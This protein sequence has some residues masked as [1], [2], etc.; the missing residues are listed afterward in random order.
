M[1][2]EERF[3]KTGVII[4]AAIII[5]MLVG[6]VFSNH[7]PGI[8]RFYIMVFLAFIGVPIFYRLWREEK[9][10][11]RGEI[12]IYAEDVTM[13]RYEEIHESVKKPEW[14]HSDV[15]AHMKRLKDEQ[16]R[17]AAEG[18]KSKTDEK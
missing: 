4:S 12:D 8:Q 5:L 1:I 15:S 17:L 11:D 14:I 18:K 6:I 9:S 16:E 10:G 3:S 13:L 7:S 2:K